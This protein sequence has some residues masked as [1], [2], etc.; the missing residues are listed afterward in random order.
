MSVDSSLRTR[1]FQRLG[2]IS[3]KELELDYEAYK[4]LAQKYRRIAR[5][6]RKRIDEVKALLRSVGVQI[7]NAED[8]GNCHGRPDSESLHN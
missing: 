5:A 2:A 6:K 3:L 8:G 1:E 4:R 7:V